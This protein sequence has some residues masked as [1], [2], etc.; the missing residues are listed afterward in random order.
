MN[1]RLTGLALG[2]FAIGTDAYVIAAILDK[3]GADLGVSTAATGQLVTVFALT[4]AL[5]APVLAAATATWPRRHVLLGALTVLTAG[6]LTTVLATG[7]ATAMAG[8]IVAAAGASMFTPAAAA[9]A[10]GL[11]PPERRARALAVVV[12]GLTTAM[13]LGVP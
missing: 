6:N 11:V 5:L 13:V 9:V 1:L 2:T 10:A 4:Y 7:Y 8:R 12:A 3:I